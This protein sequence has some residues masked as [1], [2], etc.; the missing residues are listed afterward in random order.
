MEAMAALAK[1]WR[2]S[3]PGNIIF[4]IFID[5]G[6]HLGTSHESGFWLFRIQKKEQNYWVI[7]L[8]CLVKLVLLKELDSNEATAK[9]RALYA[10]ETKQGK[11]VSLFPLLPAFFIS[12]NSSRFFKTNTYLNHFLLIKSQLL[13]C[14]QGWPRAPAI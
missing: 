7:C 11:I 9:N 6:L 2:T 5:A 4:D 10:L 13:G 12:D 1:R 3:F 8:V 14:F